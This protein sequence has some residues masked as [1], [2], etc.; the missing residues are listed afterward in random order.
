MQVNVTG[1]DYDPDGD[2]FQVIEVATPAHG[3]ITTFSSVFQYTPNAGFSGVETITYT[4]RD[5]H[6]LTSTGLVTVLVGAIGDQP[7]VAQSAGYSVQAGATLPITL[8]AVD[9]NGAAAHVEARHA[10]RSVS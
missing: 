10:R 2:S 7:P 1:N 4:I 9:P 6:G 5:T 3:V 8:S